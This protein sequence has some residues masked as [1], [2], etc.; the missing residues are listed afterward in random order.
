MNPNSVISFDMKN[1][2]IYYTTLLHKCNHIIII[3]TRYE[4]DKHDCN[5]MYNT[6]NTFYHRNPFCNKQKTQH[7]AK[8]SQTFDIK[9]KF[10]ISCLR[11]IIFLAL[12]SFETFLMFLC[13]SF[14]WKTIDGGGTSG[15]ELNFLTTFFLLRANRE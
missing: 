10:I 7:K 9:R 12:S 13:I 15:N 4:D 8:R 5:A 2:I 3:L 6:F 14:I 11:T 1:I